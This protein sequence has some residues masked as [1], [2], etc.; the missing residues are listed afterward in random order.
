MKG[1]EFVYESI[2][3]MDYKL[4]KVSLR[5]GRSYLKFPEWF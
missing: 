1:S 3:L 4:H 5:R 2:E